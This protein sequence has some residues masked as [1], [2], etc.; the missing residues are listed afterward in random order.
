MR[1]IKENHWMDFS[2]ARSHL[3]SFSVIFFSQWHIEV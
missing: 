3:D 1:P 2:L